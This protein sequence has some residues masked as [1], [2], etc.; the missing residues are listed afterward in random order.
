MKEIDC[1]DLID[2]ISKLNH[3]LIIPSHV[4]DELKDKKTKTTCDKLI[5]EKKLKVSNLNSIGEITDLQK[6]Y[7]YLGK[8]ELDSMLHYQKL[9]GNEIQVYCIFD[10]GR[11]R[12]TATLNHIPHTGLLGL[13]QM[14]RDKSIITTTEYK[15]II[16]S[17]QNSNFRIPK[18]F[19]K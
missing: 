18:E 16:N 7:P 11:A 17:L 8:G 14:I 12:K 13:L 2:A 5:E 9:S 6:T 10:D 1:P 3:E 19:V 4:Y 15:S